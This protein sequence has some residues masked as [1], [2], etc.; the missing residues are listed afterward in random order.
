MSGLAGGHPPHSKQMGGAS[1]VGSVLKSARAKE[2]DRE[3][4]ARLN[5]LDE[6]SEEDATL[7][8]SVRLQPPRCAVSVVWASRGLCVS[9]EA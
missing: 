4:K 5:M 7:P 1:E 3:R 9:C 2:L 8:P 6:E